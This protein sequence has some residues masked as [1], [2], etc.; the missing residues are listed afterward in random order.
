MNKNYLIVLLNYNN[1]QDTVECINSLKNCGVKDSNILVIENCSSDDSV[2]KLKTES[3]EVSIIELNKNLGFTGG[4]NVGIKYA[5]DNNYD[6]AIALNNDTIVESRD[7]IRILIAE[8]DNNPDVT[9]GTG[10]IFYYPQKDLV[11]FDG[12]KLIKW[13]ASAIHYNFRQNKHDI[14]LNNKNM[15]IDFISGCFMC[16]RLKDFSKLGY[17]DEN[18]FIYLDD[19]EY[20]ARA[21]KNNLKLMYFHKVVIYHKALGEGKRTPKMIYY[22]IRNRRL[23]INLHFGFIAKIY[24]KLVLF[25]KKAY[26]FFTSKKYYN[27]LIR[28]VKDYKRNYFGQVPEFI[29]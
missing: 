5:L 23:L 6:Y 2:K 20:S 22:T 28:A 17:M 18:F 24:F 3:P 1:W 19:I 9:I 7:S 27:I 14:K 4:N 8:M 29:K 11:W 21:I 26:W 10:R 13:K 25:F 15:E 12:G 16:I